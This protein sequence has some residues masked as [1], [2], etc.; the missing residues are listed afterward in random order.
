MRLVLISDTHA[1]HEELGSLSGD[2]LIH[3]GDF[4]DGFH[5]DEDD[6]SNIDRWFGQQ[7]FERIL[8]VG[9]NHDFVA[10]KRH[11][12][13]ERVFE[14]AIYLEDEAYEFGGIK[15]YGSPWLP[16]LEGWAY[17]LSDE[18]RREKWKLIPADTDVLITH[19]P[20]RGILDR[21]RSGTP[22]GCSHLRAALEDLALRIH[23]FGHVHA[24][25]GK[26]EEFQITFYN[27]AVVDSAYNVSHGP[28]VVDL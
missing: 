23:C 5:E 28:I 21:S 4:C 10:Q 2:V 25:H 17:Y 3:C 11:A 9:G 15:F 12:S 14:N 6:L 20:P 18:E 13:G 22:V 19:T 8:C 1:V 26:W 16:D 7:E 24:S 27:A